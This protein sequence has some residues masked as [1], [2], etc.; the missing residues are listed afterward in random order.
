MEQ[1]SVG[2]DGIGGE[3]TDDPN[4]CR[5]LDRRMEQDPEVHHVVGDG[6]LTVRRNSGPRS[7]R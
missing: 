5:G 1:V 7:P 2:E 4:G 6:R 3:F